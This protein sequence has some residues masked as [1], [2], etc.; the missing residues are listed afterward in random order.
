VMTAS[1]IRPATSNKFNPA[2]NV[3]SRPMTGRS[4]GLARVRQTP[5]PTRVNESPGYYANLLQTKIKEI[6]AEIN[7]L[8]TETELA[9]TSSD[10]R[11]K[12]EI[13]YEDNLDAVQKLEG[14]IADYNLAKDKA[15]VG[16][17]YED[18]RDSALDV[19]DSNAKLGEEID[20]IFM[21]RKKAEGEAAKLESELKKIHA[22]V[23]SK[24]KDTD[25]EKLY[26]YQSLVEEITNIQSESKAEE[27]EMMILKDKIKH[28]EAKSAQSRYNEAVT[29]VEALKQSI[30]DTDDDIELAAMD[31]DD[32]REHLLNQVKSIQKSVKLLD[33]KS[34]TLHSEVDNL[35]QERMKLRSKLR[36]KARSSGSTTAFL[37]KKDE[38]I[39]QFLA[40]LPQMK[41]RL[42]EEQLRVKATI[43]ALREDIVKQDSLSKAMPTKA[44]LEMM[45][46]EAAFT[47]NHLDH[48]QETMDHLEQ[49]KKARVEEVT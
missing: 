29:R 31:E 35:R 12:I 11:R 5:M 33:A 40:D 26:H 43:Q 3:S 21:C 24:Y 42:E 13:D 17:G 49:Q 20:G 36:N 46:D 41:T 15:R 19:L 25:P 47:M 7:R 10:S 39:K 38:E 28:L 30:R 27:D 14:K 6:V 44:E 23:E 22:S 48:N 45:K 18:L 9:D 16:V 32:A 2:K 8:A 4:G 1:S 37:F 34:S